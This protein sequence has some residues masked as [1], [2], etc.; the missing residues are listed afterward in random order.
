MNKFMKMDF[1]LWDRKI[2]CVELKY[3]DDDEACPIK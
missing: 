3:D 2:A 1:L